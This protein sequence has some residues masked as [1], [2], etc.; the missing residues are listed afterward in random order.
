MFTELLVEPEKST[1]VRL[2]GVPY[3]GELESTVVLR[4]GARLRIRAIRPDDAPRLAALFE[5]LSPQTIYQ[6]FFTWYRR[7][8]NAWYHEFA[9]V[10]YRARLALV[11]EDVTSAG[12]LLRG[13]ARWEPGDAHDA[14]ELAV[15]VEDAWQSR[16]LGTRL[17]TA[18]FDAAEARSI[19]RF[20][21]DVL[22]ENERM[23]RLLKRLGEIRASRTEHGVTHLCLIPRAGAA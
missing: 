11:A 16:G 15:V 6:R 13:V 12:V 1:I 19:R 2:S 9:N 14:A 22:A 3:P 8:P 20:C 4:D 5:R 10:D 21:A 17:M 7:L 18:I 23:L